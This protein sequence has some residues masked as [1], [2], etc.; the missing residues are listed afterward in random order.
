[1]CHPPIVRTDV[2]TRSVVGN[3]REN[4]TAHEIGHILG[5]GASFT[6]N[7]QVVGSIHHNNRGSDYLMWYNNYAS[8]PCRISR[9]DWNLI[10]FTQGTMILDADGKAH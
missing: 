7:G 4:Q 5:V 2:G 1:M 6:I 10:N 9:D 8:A 3:Y